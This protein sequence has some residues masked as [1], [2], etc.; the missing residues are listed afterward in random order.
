MQFNGFNITRTFFDQ[1]GKVVAIS[2]D[3]GIEKDSVQA[4][5]IINDGIF[6][7]RL[8]DITIKYAKAKVQRGHN[9]LNMDFDIS[10]ITSYIDKI[11]DMHKDVE[12]GRFFLSLRN[13][14]LD[15]TSAGYKQYYD[16]LKNERLD[17]K[18]FIVP[19]SYGHYKVAG[20]SIISLYNQGLFSIAVNVK[21]CSRNSFVNAMLINT[22]NLG[23]DYGQGVLLKTIKKTFGNK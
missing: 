12:L 18:S 19:R 15:S 5:E 7:L 14:P 21:E 17:G 1:G 4:N 11:G 22:A 23:L 13:A 20:D 16:G 6:R 9:T 10:F 2:A 8:K 3:F